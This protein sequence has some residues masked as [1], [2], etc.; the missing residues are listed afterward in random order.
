MRCSSIGLLQAVVEEQAK[1]VLTDIEA[2]ADIHGGLVHDLGLD[3]RQRATIRGLGPLIQ[4]SISK[5]DTSPKFWLQNPTRIKLEFLVEFKAQREGE[6]VLTIVFNLYIAAICGVIVGF[7]GHE[8][9]TSIRYKLEMTEEFR[10]LE[11]AHIQGIFSI[12]NA[13]PN[14]G[15]GDAG[16]CL[17]DK[18]TISIGVAYA[19]ADGEGIFTYGTIG[20]KAK[21]IKIAHRIAR[22]AIAFGFASTQIEGEAYAENIKTLRREGFIHAH[23]DAVHIRVGVVGIGTNFGTRDTFVRIEWHGPDTDGIAYARLRTTKPT[24]NI[25]HRAAI[26]Y[27]HDIVVFRCDLTMSVFHQQRA[28][29]SVPQAS[30]TEPTCTTVLRTSKVAAEL[31]TALIPAT[32]LPELAPKFARLA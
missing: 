25:A 14:V 1:F 16:A 6:H 28:T 27:F 20:R 32:V 19:A 3:G 31:R 13:I 24:R 2:E 4:I 5:N 21:E 8:A 26:R 17:G 12:Q 30:A 9:N 18:F 10:A 15:I 7:T 29:S 23:G 22:I 11:A